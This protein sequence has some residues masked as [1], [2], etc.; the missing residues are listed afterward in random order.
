[1]ALDICKL[2]VL[3]FGNLHL[4]V[5][6][7]LLPIQ[8]VPV[9]RVDAS[10]QQYA[11]QDLDYRRTNLAEL[12]RRRSHRRSRAFTLRFGYSQ[13]IDSDHSCS[14]LLSAKPTATAN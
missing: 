2:A 1:C 12:H 14:K 9:P 6:V 8:P 7:L 3:V 5:N 11:D 4:R 13:Q 10:N